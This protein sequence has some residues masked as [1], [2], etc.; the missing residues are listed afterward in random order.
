MNNSTIIGNTSL[1]HGGGI[2]GESTLILKNSTVSGNIAHGYGGGISNNGTLALNNSTV[3][4]NIAYGYGGAI[5][6][7]GNRT[8]ALYN[9]TVSENTAHDSGG[10]IYNS[11]INATISLQN[12][13]ISGN[14]AGNSPDCWGTVDSAGYNLIGDTSGCTFTPGTGDLINVG[15]NLG[16]LI[17]ARG[18]PWYHPLLPVSPAIDAGNPAGCFFRVALKPD[19][20]DHSKESLVV[21]LSGYRGIATERALALNQESLNIVHL[22]EEDMVKMFAASVLLM[23]AIAKQPIDWTQRKQLIKR[24][25]LDSVKQPCSSS[26]V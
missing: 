4:G 2:F 17:G 12:T 15:A 13:I 5:L 1:Q 22:H 16:L 19:K 9:S 26:M 6:N 24:T 25:Q 11:S 21:N 20:G 7:W 8:A 23:A 18:A 3:S 14:T 10:G